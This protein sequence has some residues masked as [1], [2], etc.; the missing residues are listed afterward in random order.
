MSTT[1]F[2]RPTTSRAAVNRAN[3]QRSTGPRT[4]AG[5]Q[6]SSLNALRHGLTAR[7]AV[8]PSE[9]SAG[10]EGHVQQFLDEYQPATPTET[11]LVHELAN[12]AWRLNRVPFLEAEVLS[13][14][15]VDILDAHRALASLGIHGQR[16]SRQF[17]KTLERL[18]DVQQERRAQERR[19]LRDAADLLVHHQHKGLPWDPAAD[20][21]VFTKE[22]VER[23]AQHLM[24]QNAAYHAG[25][26]RFQ[27]GPSIAKSERGTSPVGAP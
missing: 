6:R 16:L 23:H 19:Q 18:R 17:Q 26:V 25:Y 20:G 10:F 7:I 1:A 9:D 8:L 15:D 3:A 12:T 27:M 11:Q 24:R 4:E 22:Q 21:F 5:K 13:R 14:A 2:A